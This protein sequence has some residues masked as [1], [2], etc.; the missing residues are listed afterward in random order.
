MAINPLLSI[1]EQRI[2][3]AI[4]ELMAE[5]PYPP[6]FREIQKRAGLSSISIVGYHMPTLQEKGYLT[7][8][9]G[10]S[11]TIQLKKEA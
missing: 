7:Y 5:K 3:V 8:E 10:K 9:D 11:R 6:T 2:L 4:R 1:P